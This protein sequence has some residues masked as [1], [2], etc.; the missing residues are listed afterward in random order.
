MNNWN[1]AVWRA[2]LAQDA[3]PPAFEFAFSYSLPADF[4]KMIEFN[5]GGTPLVPA[6]GFINLYPYISRYVIEGKKLLTNDPQAFVKYLRDINNPDLWDP[7]FYQIAAAWLTSKLA[8]AITKSEK[9]AMSKM[10]EVMKI[11]LPMGIN[12]DGQE[13]TELPDRIDTLIRNR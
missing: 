8:T 13:G 2:E 9:L 3:I 5:G 4:V 10:E 1:F 11:L 6:P 7:L 12:V